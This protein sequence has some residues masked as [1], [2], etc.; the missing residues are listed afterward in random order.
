MRLRTFL[1]VSAAMLVVVPVGAQA[2]VPRSSPPVSIR[3]VNHEFTAFGTALAR[4]DQAIAPVRV[5]FGT[6]EARWRRASADPDRARRATEM[7]A[8]V[9]ELLAE[10]DRTDAALAAIEAPELRLLAHSPELQPAALIA[11]SRLSMIQVRSGIRELEQLVEAERA[12]DPAAAERA[13]VAMM[14]SLGHAVETRALLSRAGMEMVPPESSARQR[15]NVDRLLIRITG[16]VLR[17]WQSL[18]SRDPTLA[19]DFEAIADELDE[20]ARIGS[21]RLERE[22]GALDAARAMAASRGDSNAATLAARV[23]EVGNAGRPVYPLARELAAMV[24]QEAR[25]FAEGNVTAEH[26]VAVVMRVRPF[27]ERYDAISR[28]EIATMAAQR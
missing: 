23:V 27:R 6:M 17:A 8:M 5:I 14:V 13:S 9:A 18:G 19:S 21:E 12:N 26:L 22:L 10:L 15:A 24:R 4:I 11:T 1:A 25:T 28:V 16:R 7:R 20:T 2:P 3:Q